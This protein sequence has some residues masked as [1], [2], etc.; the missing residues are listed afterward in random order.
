[1]SEPTYRR[2]LSFG[3]EL[4]WR[5]KA[6]W[7]LGL[8]AAMLGH[9]GIIDLVSKL[10]L[11]ATQFSAPNIWVSLIAASSE[12]G[13]G[14][15]GLGFQQ[16][17]LV[18]WLLAVL[19]G[20]LF[21]LAFVATAAQGALIH[22]AATFSKR[23]RSLPSM[24][25][26]WHEGVGHFW[27]LFAL[28]VVKKFIL[29]FMALWVAWSALYAFASNEASVRAAFVVI[30][31]IAALVGLVLSFL[32]IYAAGYVVVEGYSFSAAVREAWR[33]F[34]KHPLVSIEMGVIMLLVHL[35]A[36]SAVVAGIYVVFAPAMVMWFVAQFLS[37]S[38]LAGIGLVAGLIALGVLIAAVGALIG[39][40][41]I[42]VWTYLF[43]KMHGSGVGSRVRYWLKYAR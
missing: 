43:M 34:L 27:T 2:A 14:V 17:L 41:T 24:R 40:F 33:L 8:F 22:A 12:G 6:L 38:I 25:E 15:A 39:V 29:S 36:A 26:S 30:F 11:A 37:S 19:L 42:S 3:W 7:L 35:V 9:M 20:T 16:V 13:V 4:A 21:I 28:N 1:M 31:V 32:L 5:H 18:L 10:F 23:G